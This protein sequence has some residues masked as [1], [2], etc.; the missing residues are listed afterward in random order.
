MKKVK[1]NNKARLDIRLS[2]DQKELFNRAA[3]LAGYANLSSFILVTVQE[4]AMNIIKQNE[5]IITSIKDAEIFFDAILNPKQP[6]NAL[7]EAAKSFKS[8][9]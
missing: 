6:N 8:S 9:I 2:V 7:T 5:T 1:I 3:I 4:K